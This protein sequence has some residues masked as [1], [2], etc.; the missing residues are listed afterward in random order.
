V[1]RVVL[2]GVPPTTEGERLRQIGHPVFIIRPRDDL[3]DSTPRAREFLPRARPLDLP[4]AGANLFEAGAE[5][6]VGAI[7]EFLAG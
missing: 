6:A 2:V 7:R 3:W 4:Q 5:A 1:R